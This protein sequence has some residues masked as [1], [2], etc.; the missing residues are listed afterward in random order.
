MLDEMDYWDVDY[1]SVGEDFHTVV[2][3]TVKLKKN[4]RLLPIAIPLNNE[5]VMGHTYAGSLVARYSQS[6]RHALGI[7]STAYLLQH[8]LTSP[9]S[10]RKSLLFLLCLECHTLPLLYFAS[11]AY[12]AESALL[13]DFHV[14]FHGGK[15]LLLGLLSVASAVLFNLSFTLYKSLQ[16]YVRDRVFAKPR[17][18]VGDIASDLCDLAVQ[19]WC[20]VGYFIVPFGF[21]AYQNLMF[22]TNTTYYNRLEETARKY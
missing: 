14:Y 15:L 18:I 16:F 13:G 10:P 11:G 17:N 21:R 3:A 7:S 1:D 19:A 5:N 22:R 6:M 9:F 20:T 2:K 12:V 4:V 8:L